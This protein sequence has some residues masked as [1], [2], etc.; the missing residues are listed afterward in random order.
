MLSAHSTDSDRPQ[1]ALRFPTIGHL[2]HEIAQSI[3]R[4]YAFL[5]VLSYSVWWVASGMYQGSSNQVFLK[6]YVHQNNYRIHW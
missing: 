6:E 2:G 5:F 1:R 4:V 3:T